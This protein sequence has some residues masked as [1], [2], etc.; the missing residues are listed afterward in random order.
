MDRQG[1][2]QQYRAIDENGFS[3][4]VA[5]YL[6]QRLAGAGIF[7][8]REVEV[9]RHPGAPIGQRTDILI[10]TLRRSPTGEPIDPITA[11]IEAKGCWNDELFTALESQLVQRY[12]VQLG[13]SVGVYLVG[14]FDTASWDPKDS[15]RRD[16]PKRPVDEVRQELD[17]QAAGVP[18]GFLVRSVVMEIGSP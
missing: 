11:V 16:V 8:N 3:D 6:R 17:A 15:R 4:V 2:T 10:N 5:R 13:A 9:L 7:A 1:T 14:W 12:M 18:E